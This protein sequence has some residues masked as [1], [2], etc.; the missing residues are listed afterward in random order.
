MFEY[1]DT[2][3]KVNVVSSNLIA[4]SITCTKN[5]SKKLLEI[6]AKGQTY[7]AVVHERVEW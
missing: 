3:A 6:I 5:L 4:C 2:I 7:L 1:E